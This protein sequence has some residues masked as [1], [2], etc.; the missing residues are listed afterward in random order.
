MVRAR[1]AYCVNNVN[2]V[3]SLSMWLVQYARRRLP[4]PLRLGAVGERCYS[5][6][7]RQPGETDSCTALA[8][9]L[10]INTRAARGAARSAHKMTRA[11]QEKPSATVRRDHCLPRCLP[12][13][14][15]AASDRSSRCSSPLSPHPHA[16]AHADARTPA[17]PPAPRPCNAQAAAAQA[18]RACLSACRTASVSNGCS[19]LRVSTP[20]SAWSETIV[21]VVREE[22]R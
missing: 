8:Q 6:A 10:C 22:Q 20:G 13:A 12:R 17:L 16:R 21:R 2:S 3:S 9:T 15:A 5:G 4:C 11:V 1:R 14:A 18:A 7:S 19:K